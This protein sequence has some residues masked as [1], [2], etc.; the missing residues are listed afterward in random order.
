MALATMTIDPTA[1]SY[2]DDE[3]VGKIN[4]AAAKIS[5]S[6][7]LDYDALNLVITGPAAGEHKVKQLDRLGTGELEVTYDDV[8]ES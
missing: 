5:R 1:T 6:D 4:T 7:A 3:I 8:A 2:T